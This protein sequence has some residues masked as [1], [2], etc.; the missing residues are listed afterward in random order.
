MQPILDTASAGVWVLK[1]IQSQIFLKV[2]PSASGTV[3][4]IPSFLLFCRLGECA[5]LGRGHNITH[6][7]WQQLSVLVCPAFACA[8]LSG[9]G[10]GTIQQAGRQMMCSISAAFFAVAS[11]GG[12]RRSTTAAATALTAIE[13]LAHRMPWSS[14][15]VIGTCREMVCQFLWR[16]WLSSMT[17]SWD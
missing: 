8:C 11:V 17:S 5:S 10:R 7:L 15:P 6:I 13:V 12:D 14:G 16:A 9:H 1:A 3:A 4:V 2:R